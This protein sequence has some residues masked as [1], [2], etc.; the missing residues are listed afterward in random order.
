MKPDDF[1][2]IKVLGKGGYGTVLLVRQKTTGRLFAQKQLKK[3]SLVVQA[4]IIG[5][6]IPLLTFTM[7]NYCVEYTKSERT[8]LEEIKNPF[9]VKLFYAFQDSSKLYLILEYAAGGELFHHLDTEKMFSEDVAAFYLAEVLIALTALHSQGVIYRDLKPEN[10]LLDAEG[11]LLL[12]DFG[13]SKVT[14]LPSPSND[15]TAT[16]EEE[17]DSRASSMCGT[18]EY[19]APEM[20][21]GRPYGYEVDYWAMGV[22]LHEL[23]TGSPPF[24]G[25]NNRLICDRIIKSKLKLPYYISPDAKDL[26]TKLLKKVPTARLGCKKGDVAKIRAHRFFRKVDWA[27]LERR[28]V[29]APIRPIITD[30]EKAEN[31]PRF[32]MLALPGSVGDTSFLANGDVFAENVFAG[33]T[34]TASESFIDRFMEMRTGD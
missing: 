21:Q 8:I 7:A 31:F 17:T 32:N 2:Q 3:A 12:T 6:S 22:L 29:E 11:H 23:L 9:V 25:P 26:L 28:E 33:F 30:A 1:E 18:C 15:E 16:E 20:I 4:K 27:R 10:C 19:M 13:L 5:T 24:T 34:Y 14:P